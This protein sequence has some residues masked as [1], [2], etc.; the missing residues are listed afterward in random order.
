MST[1]AGAA[2]SSSG[3]CVQEQDE[4]FDELL[5]PFDRMAFHRICH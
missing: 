4:T 3:N 1:G 5:L 2:F